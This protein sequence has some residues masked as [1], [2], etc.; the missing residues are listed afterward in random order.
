VEAVFG[1]ESVPV[2]T[3]IGWPGQVNT[4]RVDVRVPSGAV[5]GEAGV[6]LTA[7]W[8]PGG[9]FRVPVRN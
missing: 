8:I 7:A 9:V 1:T 6:Q 5:T 3:K 2:I 4:Y